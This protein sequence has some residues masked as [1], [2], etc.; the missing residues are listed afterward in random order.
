MDDG[1]VETEDD[2]FGLKRPDEHVGVHDHPGL[3]ERL[4]G[5][6]PS[7]VLAGV[8]ATSDGEPVDDLRHRRVEATHQQDVRV[9]LVDK[10]QAGGPAVHMASL[11]A[12]LPREVQRAVR[13][14]ANPTRGLRNSIDNLLSGCCR[15][16]GEVVEQGAHPGAELLVI[17]VDAG[18][19]R[20][21]S[22]WPGSADAGED[23]CDDLV[24]QGE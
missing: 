3:L 13:H 14:R 1:T 21:R 12:V 6:C 9:A 18:V 22:S 17:A 16:D 20:G 4:T 23:R 11:R 24:A 7:W 5:G 15:V 2:E 19:C 8:H 10:H